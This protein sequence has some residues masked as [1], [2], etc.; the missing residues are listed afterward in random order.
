MSYGHQKG[1]NRNHFTGSQLFI[2]AGAEHNKGNPTQKAPYSTNNW[3][4]NSSSNKQPWD[5]NVKKGDIIPTIIRK[6]N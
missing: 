3:I 4:Y 1:H 2:M 6:S 5:F